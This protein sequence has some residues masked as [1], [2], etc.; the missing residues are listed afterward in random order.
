[1]TAYM[2]IEDRPFA[3]DLDGSIFLYSDEAVC[4]LVPR[5]T[6]SLT[7]HID[8]RILEDAVNDVIVLFPHMKVRLVKDAAGFMYVRNDARIPV[9]VCSRKDVSLSDPALNGYLFCVSYSAKTVFLDVHS[10]LLDEKGLASFAKAIVFRYIQL[11]GYPVE[12]DGSVRALPEGQLHVSL[13]DP[14]EKIEDIPAARPVW[15]MDA[16]A[17]HA[18]ETCAG[19]G[20]CPDKSSGAKFDAV[21]IRIPLHRLRSFVK[22]YASLPEILISS[23][24]S[25]ALYEQYSDDM[26]KGEY[27]VASISVNLRR[28]F[29]TVSLKPF[30]TSVTL[31]C[32]R[33]LGEYPFN[34]ILMS[35][36]KLLEAQLKT[37]AL[38]YNAQQRIA[39]FGKVRSCPD[40][41]SRCSTASGIISKKAEQSTYMLRNAGTIG[42]PE[43]MLRYVTEFYPM[44]TPS[45]HPL[46]FSSIIF[47][48]EVILT[49]ASR[50]GYL[51]GLCRKIV[52][53]MN[54]NDIYAY[55]SDEFSFN[56]VTYRL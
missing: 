48:N 5:F 30:S 51:P 53:L 11:S 42:M 25:Q 54:G 39:D 56:P 14:F 29:P 41:A 27:V 38:A 52:S 3:P 34:T 47:R 8:G 21:Q 36:K 6:V 19:D 18:P 13:E 37:D 24:V 7:M 4:G 2:D 26:E 20:S 28:Y 9:S 45:V 31:A 10:S 40:F 44:Y 1:M 33:R 46:S 22:E 49:A 35:Q 32:N 12:N 15:Y 23:V 43:S 55:I 50:H 16:K 17:F